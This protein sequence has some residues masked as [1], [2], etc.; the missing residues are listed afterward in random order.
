MNKIMRF[1]SGS[2]EYQK[3]TPLKPGQQGPKMER[4]WYSDMSPGNTGVGQAL[5]KT[6]GMFKNR[7][8]Q[9]DA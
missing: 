7:K 1:L 5:R 4:P 8:K 3:T 9:A 6:V 2:G